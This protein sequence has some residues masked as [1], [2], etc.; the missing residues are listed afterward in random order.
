MARFRN[1]SRYSNGSFTLSSKNKEFLILRNSLVIPPSPDDIYVT[2][3]GRYYQRID[4]VSQDVYGRPDLGWVI[5]DINNIKQPMFDLKTGV[6]LRV[7]PLEAV[8]IA[9]EKLNVK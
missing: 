9:I 3:D 4:L 8:L 6:T 7:P 5:M 2:I 1:G